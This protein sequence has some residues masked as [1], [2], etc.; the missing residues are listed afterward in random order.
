MYRTKQHNGEMDVYNQSLGLYSTFWTCFL[1]SDTSKL[2]V[3]CPPK[4]LTA[5]SFPPLDAL[6]A[7]ISMTLVM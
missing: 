2:A 4:I 5:L 6:A 1:S 3:S 7:A